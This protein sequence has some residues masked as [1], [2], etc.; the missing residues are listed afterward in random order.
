VGHE[1]CPR[2][3]SGGAPTAEHEVT[4]DHVAGFDDG[5]LAIPAFFATPERTPAPGVL[6]LHD[7]NGPNDFYHDL[8]RRLAAEGFVALL[9]DLFHRLEPLVEPTREAARA[10]GAQL[11]QSQT[12]GDIHASLIWLAE[13]GATTGQVGTVGFC[14]G[15][16]LVM[17]AAARDPLPAASVAFYGFPVRERTPVATKRPIDDDE[18]AGVESPLLLFWGDGDHGVGMDNVARYRAALD[19]YGRPAET[20]IYPGLGHGFLTFDP[21]APAYAAS[22][23]AW[24]R[25]LA[26]FR[27]RFDAA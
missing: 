4:I 1:I 3:I 2:P 18:V 7:I 19:R 9:P 21:G 11:D 27:A 12:L 20:V 8:A 23:D 5:R 6:I 24:E 13:H 10:R 25:T 14:M 16:T 15:G 22:Q 26:F 17:L